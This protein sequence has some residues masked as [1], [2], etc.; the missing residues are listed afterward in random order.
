MIII[1]IQLI[2]TLD[3]SEALLLYMYVNKIL[4]DLGLS[5]NRTSRFKTTAN[6]IPTCVPGDI[7]VAGLTLFF[8]N[9][10]PSVLDVIQDTRTKA[11]L[12][13]FR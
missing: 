1:H 13:D 10:P 4:N 5:S 11:L 7:G 8:N 3:Q 9:S 6:Q 2:E 12:Y